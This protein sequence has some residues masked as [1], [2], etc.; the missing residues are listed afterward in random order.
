MGVFHVFWFV[1]IVLNQATHHIQKSGK[2][3]I[4]LIFDK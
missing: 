1:Q 2:M 4:W 3:D